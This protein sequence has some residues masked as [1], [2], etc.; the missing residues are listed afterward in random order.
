MDLYGDHFKIQ[1]GGRH[2]Q[3]QL[4]VHISFQSTYE[5]AS[6][7][8]CWCFY[9]DVNNSTINWSLT[10]GL[11]DTGASF[12]EVDLVLDNTVIYISSKNSYIYIRV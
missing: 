9:H 8:K 1:D 12:M 7:C 6:V 11:I 5:T 4:W 2:R 10:T 3:N